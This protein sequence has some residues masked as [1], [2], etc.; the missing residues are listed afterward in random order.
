[1]ETASPAGASV[2]ARSPHLASLELR[3]LV[4]AFEQSQRLRLQV[5]ERIRAVLRGEDC[6]GATEADASD[7]DQMLK[8]IRRGETDGPLPSLGRCYQIFWKQEKEVSSALSTL[9]LEHPTWPWLLRVRGVGAHLAGKLLGHLDISRAKT[10][11]AFWAYCGFATVP[12]NEFTCT[13]CGYQD[14]YPVTHRPAARHLRPHSRASCPGALVQTR[15]PA[16]GVRVAQQYGID[17]HPLYNRRA[18][19]VCYLIGVSM[20]RTGGKYAEYCREQRRDIDEKHPFWPPKRRHNAA[21][22][23]TEKLFLAHLWSVWAS[24]LGMVG[25]RTYAFE[26]LGHP[27]LD[28]WTMAEPLGS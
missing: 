13:T 1:M 18:K 11:S 17:G 21:L 15:G 19:T 3:N 4:D 10:P 24:E 8:R 28:P 6:P 7:A 20:L 26:R 9:V 22:R 25:R 14:A 12:G 2:P 5:G 16:D 23:K 27:W